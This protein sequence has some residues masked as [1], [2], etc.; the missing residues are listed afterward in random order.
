M[1]IAQL[2]VGQWLD[3]KYHLQRYIGRG[4]F[5]Y[6]FE[7]DHVVA[8]RSMSCS[9]GTAERPLSSKRQTRWCVG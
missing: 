6:V 3:G 5:G 4:S 9:K 8:A 2:L 7:A 1:S